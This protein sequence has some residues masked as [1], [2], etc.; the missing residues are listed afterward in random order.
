MTPLMF[1]TILHQASIG[2]SFVRPCF[3]TDGKQCGMVFVPVRTLADQLVWLMQ[4]LQSNRARLHA[5]EQQRIKTKKQMDV[6]P[7]PDNTK[8]AK[9]LGGTSCSSS[10]E[11]RKMRLSALEQEQVDDVTEV[12]ILIAVP[13]TS[14]LPP[15]IADRWGGRKARRD[16]PQIM[17]P[18]EEF[19][20]FITPKFSSPKPSEW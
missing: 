9:R 11:M 15:S 20:R 8:V 5:R 12:S 3:A 10:E 17:G 16:V 7:A 14:P 18:E 4:L 13:N 19:E 6:V 1:F 2:K